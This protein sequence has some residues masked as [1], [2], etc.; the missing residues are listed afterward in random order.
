MLVVGATGTLGRQIVRRALDEGYDVRCIVRPRQNP[1][2][3]LRDW[4]AT[5]VQAD[6]TDPTSLP[7]AMVGIHTVV[8]CAT[9]RPE[10]S[11]QKVD[12]EGKVALVQA[13][14]AVGV[15]RYV[16]FSIHAADRHPEVPLM[17]V[18][19]ATEKFLETSGLNYTTFR[20]CGFMQALIG[21]YAVPILEE[22][23]VWGTSDATRTAY[24]DTQDVA[25]L[26][27]A[28]LRTEAA[29]GR[30]LTLAGPKAWTV[31]EVIALCEEL[32]SARAE[33]TRVPI[34]LL[35]ATRSTLRGFQWA[36]DAAD[37]LAFAD[38]L[39]SNEDF[40]APMDDTYALLGVDPASITTLEAY[41]KE[42]YSS[43][44]KKLKEVGATSRQTDFYV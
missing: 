34:W 44:M 11:T 42:Y 43:I 5:T 35:R 38:I 25:R 27:L 17:Q 10:E 40:S 18:K 24:L 33:V 37:R 36:R 22:K 32:A 2:D 16:F 41:L 9:A 21:N 4:G 19:A 8:D 7:A 20:L 1:A 26:A 3:F 23:T 28:S 29:V 30:T 39:S 12:W 13:A 31:A 15:Q 14:Q 6:L